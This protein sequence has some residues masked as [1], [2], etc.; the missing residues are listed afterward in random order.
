MPVLA[1]LGADAAKLV[2]FYREELEDIATE[3]HAL[4]RRLAD[5]CDRLELPLVVEPLWYALP[6]EDAGRPRRTPRSGSRPP[7]AQPQRSRSWAPT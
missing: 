5:E 1:Q 6:G 2:V 7:S 4:V 3:Q